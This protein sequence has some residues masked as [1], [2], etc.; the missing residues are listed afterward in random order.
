MGASIRSRL[1]QRAGN[2][3]ALNGTF[4]RTLPE[5]DT[6]RTV[7]CYTE[8]VMSANHRRDDGHPQTSGTN[9]QQQRGMERRWPRRHAWP[10]TR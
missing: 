9:D 5:E 8:A 6:E 7:K 4:R 1:A 10:A 3:S 2:L